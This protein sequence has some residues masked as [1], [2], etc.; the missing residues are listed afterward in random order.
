MSECV[1]LSLPLDIF[2]FVILDQCEYNDKKK[3]TIF[4]IEDF[5]FHVI[6]HD[7]VYNRKNMSRFLVIVNNN[8]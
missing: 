3:G 8:D 5:F 2:C 6:E 4:L 1:C 7:Y